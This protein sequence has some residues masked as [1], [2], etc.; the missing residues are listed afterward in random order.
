[1]RSRGNRRRGELGE[2]SGL[3]LD[4]DHTLDD[5]KAFPSHDLCFHS[6][7]RSRVVRKIL[8]ADWADLIDLPADRAV[9]EEKAIVT[10]HTIG[11]GWVRA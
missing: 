2:R 8:V 10:D 9:R 7:R 5:I 11:E 6:A 1:M 4:F 3:A